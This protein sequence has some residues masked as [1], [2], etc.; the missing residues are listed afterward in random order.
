[1]TTFAIIFASNFVNTKTH[2][3]SPQTQTSALK[4]V[5]P[6]WLGSRSFSYLSQLV[7]PEHM[8]VLLTRHSKLTV[9][10]TN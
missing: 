1:M 7:L 9:Q 5:S 8:H 2:R 3:S 4:R 10:S 6:S